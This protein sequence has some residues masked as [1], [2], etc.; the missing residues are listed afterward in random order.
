MRSYTLVKEAITTDNYTL[1]KLITFVCPVVFTVI[2]ILYNLF[3]PILSLYVP[4]YH[5]VVCCK[6]H[7]IFKA[8]R[9]W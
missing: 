5:F 1:E 3:A 6:K 8:F 4:R 9:L 7:T 2:G